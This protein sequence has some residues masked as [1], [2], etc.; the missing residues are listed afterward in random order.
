MSDARHSSLPACPEVIFN[1]GEVIGPIFAA[2]PMWPEEN[3]VN[4]LQKLVAGV[5]SV[6][7]E[8]DRC[9]MRA[10]TGQYEADRRRFL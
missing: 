7:A 5:A 10:S 4:L 3:S 8:T 2:A 9:G 1:C 6:H